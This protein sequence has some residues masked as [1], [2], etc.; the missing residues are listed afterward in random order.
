[1]DRLAGHRMFFPELAPLDLRQEPDGLD[2]VLIDRIDMIHVVLG[3]PDDTAEIAQETAEHARLVHAGQNALRRFDR[4]R[5]LDEHP[6]RVRIGPHILVDPFQVLRHQAQCVRVNVQPLVVRNVEQTDQRNRVVRKLGVAGNVQPVA[7]EDEP[8]QIARLAETRHA[9]YRPAHILRLDRGA[10]N[11]GQIA[12]I[13]GDN[14]VV[15]HEALDIRRPGAF[16]IT[17]AL[18]DPGLHIEGQTLLGPA[19][20]VV[21]VEAHVPQEILVLGEVARLG[22]R[23]HVLVHKVGDAIDLIGVL[24]DPVEGLQITQ[25]ALAV[26]DI[27]L[28]VVTAVAHLLVAL[29]AFGQLAGDELHRGARLHL[30]VEGAAKLQEQVLITPQVTRFQQRRA[31]RQVAPGQ[32]D[33]V[34]DRA[35]GMADLQAE[36]PQHVEHVLD[37]L[38]AMGRL[39]PREQE[40]KVDI[41]KRRQLAAPVAADRDHR[42]AVARRRV[43][44][45]IRLGG[46][47][48]HDP[49]D[50]VEQKGKIALGRIA[51]D[52][53]ALEAG[54][55]MRTSVLDRG[56]HPF[57]DNLAAVPG[58]IGIGTGRHDLV[59]DLCTVDQVSVAFTVRHVGDVLHLC[60]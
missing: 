25:P 28:D 17:H 26:L 33:A 7:V 52:L 24:G 21:Q 20:D 58:G 56:A 47:V 39:L 42:H 60:P 18:G 30:V 8:H 57:E 29:V 38:L 9:D 2:R 13:L 54:A 4:T 22:A 27:G 45:G 53:P 19:G 48:V 50:L 59:F 1:M 10:E 44:G 3:L 40:Q 49:D 32:A 34:I 23:Q 55:D 46:P 51:V 16:G 41:R 43:G 6:A 12:D 5:H 35:G 31:D 37:D 36:V 14:V 11:P 15:L